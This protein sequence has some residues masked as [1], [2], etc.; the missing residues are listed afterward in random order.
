MSET[1]LHRIDH[2]LESFTAA[3][4]ANR[5]CGIECMESSTDRRV[6]S[7]VIDSDLS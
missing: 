2:D 3:K 4:A 6:P 7:Q 1:I 5:V